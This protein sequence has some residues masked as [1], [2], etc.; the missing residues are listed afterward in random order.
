MENKKVLIVEDEVSLM[1]AILEKFKDEPFLTFSA[2]DGIEGLEV[3]LKEHPDLILL[4]IIMPK[5][6]GI[7]M[8]KKLRED[9]WGKNVKV[10]ML[11]NL[12]DNE[13]L[14]EAKK[15]GADNFFIKADWK[16]EDVL[17]NVL[18]KLNE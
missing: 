3:A 7:G 16:I 6:D 14:A 8:L 5:L 10:I 1:K 4:D 2:K 9:D 12:S 17:K 18:A 13:K 15:L 11:T